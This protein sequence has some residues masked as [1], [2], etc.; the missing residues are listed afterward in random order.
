[1]MNPTIITMMTEDRTRELRGELPHS[2][3]AV[4]DLMMR[5]HARAATRLLRA[6]ARRS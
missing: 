5:R 1:M 6:V 2:R 4:S 3:R